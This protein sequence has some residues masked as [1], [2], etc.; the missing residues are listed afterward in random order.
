MYDRGI[1]LQHTKQN[2]DLIFCRHVSRKAGTVLTRPVHPLQIAKRSDDELMLAFPKDGNKELKA[3]CGEKHFALHDARSN[4]LI[5]SR[6]HLK[7]IG[8]LAEIYPEPFGCCGIVA[9][10]R[11]RIDAS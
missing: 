10:C 11:S 7:R 1:T 6:Q 8:L 4:S 3:V 9:A 5:A 2:P